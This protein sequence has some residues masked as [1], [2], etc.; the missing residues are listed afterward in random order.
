MLLFLDREDSFNSHVE[1][2]SCCTDSECN[3]PRK[4]GGREGEG[5]APFHVR[6]G[7]RDLIPRK[8]QG[9]GGDQNHLPT[10]ICDQKDALFLVEL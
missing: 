7:C 4:L 1:L 5:M 2:D 10:F 8:D 3:D 6:R 9:R